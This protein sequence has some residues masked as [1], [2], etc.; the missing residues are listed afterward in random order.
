[1]PDLIDT[2]IPPQSP[3]PAPPAATPQSLM[4]N[5][6]TVAPTSSATI[7][8]VSADETVS[9]QVKK[10]LA[11]GNPLLEAAKGDALQASAARG[12]QNSSIAAQAGTKALI[13]T[14]L[15]IAGAD[16]ATTANR[17][18]QN[19]TAVNAFGQAKQQGDINSKL[20]TEAANQK[21]T[22][23][24]QEGQQTLAQINAQTDASARLQSQ[25]QNFDLLKQDRE[26]GIQLT[27]ADK[28]FQNQQTLMIAEYGMKTGLS[29]QEQ[30]YAL[31]RLNIQNKATLD[32]IAAQSKAQAADYG[33]KLQAQYLSSVSARMEQ[34][35]QEVAAI[36]QTQGLTS[37]Q[38]TI[39][40]QNA[41]SRMQTD[42]QTMASTYAQSPLWDTG[43]GS[44]GTGGQLF[45]GAPAQVT[46]QEPIQQATVQAP[47]GNPRYDA[48]MG[49]A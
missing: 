8:G 32:Q 45:S 48:Q 19:L 35:S 36:Y 6:S 33:P 40:V 25:Q 20:Q 28:N 5:T 30:G 47:T 26:A 23:L 2:G 46:N 10:L 44:T 18:T 34:N 13:D 9:G 42:L 12:L 16:A 37:S 49:L 24:A 1:M 38:Q 41:Y 31:E 3:N 43:W 15:P 21:A 17:Q 14:A 27:L 22:L 11:D 7:G 29:Q 4:A 39:A